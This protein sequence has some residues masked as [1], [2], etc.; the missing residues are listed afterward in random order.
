MGIGTDIKC[1]DANRF[2]RP[3]TT[4][5]FTFWDSLELRRRIVAQQVP[6]QL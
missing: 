1:S 5:K 3:N 6:E 2:E 4:I